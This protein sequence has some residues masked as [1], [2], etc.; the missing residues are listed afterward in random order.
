MRTAHVHHQ[1]TADFSTCTVKTGRTG[2]IGLAG[3]LFSCVHAYL[4][5]S[6][7]LS[8]II[9]HTFS[10]SSYTSH[11]YNILRKMSYTIVH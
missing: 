5:K 1:H 4:S 8:S 3:T 2:D 11:V 10:V 6:H 9:T 7:F